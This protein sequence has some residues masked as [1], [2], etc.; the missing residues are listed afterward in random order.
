MSLV[1]KVNGSISSVCTQ[2]SLS[3][4]SEHSPL[5]LI[6][7]FEDSDVKL[8]ES[9][10]ICHYIN[11]KH[12][13]SLTPSTE[14]VHIASFQQAASAEYSYFDHHIIPRDLDRLF[15]VGG[16]M[17]RGEPD[18]NLVAFYKE[19]ICNCLDYYESI[20]SEAGIPGRK[21]FA[22]VDVYHMPWLESRKHLSSWWDI[23]Q[24]HPSWRTIT[25][26]T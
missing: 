13:G 17:G 23:F 10:A 21:A 15:I 4:V 14:P 1:P 18:A 7:A 26:K 9:C 5:G 20:L 2:R 3:Y 19:E 16:M 25:S 22:L 8:L 11:T 6:P 12:G 24:A